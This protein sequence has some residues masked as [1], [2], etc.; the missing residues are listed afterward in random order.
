MRLIGIILALIVVVVLVSCVKVVQQAQA[1]VV[2]RLGA[3]QATWGVGIHFK[4]PINKF[5]NIK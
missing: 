2:E 3:Y 5:K 4:I 1:L